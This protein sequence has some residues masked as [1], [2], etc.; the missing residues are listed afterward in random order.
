M[1][2]ILF[3]LIAI[4]LLIFTITVVVNGATL[5]NL[6][7]WG[8]KELTAQNEALDTRNGELSILIGNTYSSK[9][10]TLG[11][12][13]D[14]MKKEKEDYEAK[15]VQINDKK[16]SLQ[17]DKYDIEYLWTKLGNYANDNSVVIK[18]DVTKGSS[19]DR[20]DMNFIVRGRYSDVTQFIYDIENDSK[21]GFK[22]DDF[23]MIAADISQQIKKEIEEE[24]AKKRKEAEEAPSNKKKLEEVER[25]EKQL[26]E[27]VITGVEASFSCKD[28]I[29]EM[30]ENDVPKEEE[31][32]QATNTETAEPDATNTV[33]TGDPNAEILQN[34]RNAQEKGLDG[35]GDNTTTGA[36]T[37]TT[38]NTSVSGTTTNTV[39]Q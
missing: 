33:A 22:I 39:G 11:E 20:Y 18:I 6:K 36:T 25:L 26:S 7:I 32:E 4:I 31:K 19:K 24:L 8:V 27:Q 3:A 9:V 29:I 14:K 30:T 23:D 12:S 16:Y 21:I 35:I 10:K 37:N 5:G 34:I 1:R 13:S 28:I 2:K 17:T 15:A 38:T